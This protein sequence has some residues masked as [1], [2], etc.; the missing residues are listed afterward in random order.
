MGALVVGSIVLPL[1]TIPLT[2]VFIPNIRLDEDFLDDEGEESARS[3]GLADAG[4]GAQ[5]GGSHGLD[6]QGGVSET[7][8]HASSARFRTAPRT[9]SRLSQATGGSQAEALVRATINQDRNTSTRM[10]VF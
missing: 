2:W 10:G 7:G 3:V 4:A 8:S 1:C 9:Q 5:G 6:W